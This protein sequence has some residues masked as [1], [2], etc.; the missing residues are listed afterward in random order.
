MSVICC[1][2]FIATS[3]LS[4]LRR[5]LPYIWEMGRRKDPW[6]FIPDIDDESFLSDGWAYIF[7]IIQREMAIGEEIGCHYNLWTWARSHCRK[8]N[9]KNTL[10]A[11]ASIQYFALVSFIL[12]P[13]CKAPEPS[14]QEVQGEKQKVVGPGHA[15]RASRAASSFPGPN[16]ITCPPSR[17][18]VLYRVAKSPAVRL[19]ENDQLDWGKNKCTHLATKFVFK[20]LGFWS[21]S[22]PPTICFTWPLCKSMHGRNRARC[23]KFLNIK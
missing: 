5:Q 17:L 15:L 21:E 12:P 6:H 2:L 20:P 18:W 16:L 7:Q 10:L 11:P 13:I 9:K 1:H 3:H 4:S 23:F 19:K 14:L 8:E 22:V